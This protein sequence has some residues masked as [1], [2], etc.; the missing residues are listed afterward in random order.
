MSSWGQYMRS[1]SQT[2]IDHD[3]TAAAR[4]GRAGH[5]LAV[6]LAIA[7]VGSFDLQPVAAQSDAACTTI[8][9]DAERLTCYDRALRPAQPA[10][11][12]APTATPA[13]AVAAGAA[14]AATAAA[15][16]SPRPM[17]VAPEPVTELVVVAGVR[18][19]EGRGATFTLDSGEVW[20][21]SDSRRVNL[22]DTPFGAEI[23]PGSMDSRFLVPNGRRA[24]IRVRRVQ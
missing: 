4:A 19:L 2:P 17:P 23:R 7:A 3:I 24:G 12:A 6:L 9:N 13:P 20:V 10:Q 5:G 14:V 22:P 15:S 1:T 16:P 11:P 18:Q 21:Q 8:A